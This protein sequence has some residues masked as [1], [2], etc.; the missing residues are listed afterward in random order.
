MKKGIRRI[1]WVG[2]QDQ[3]DINTIKLHMLPIGLKVAI[4]NGE[5]LTVSKLDRRSNNNNNNNKH[6][7]INSSTLFSSNSF[8]Q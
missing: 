2:V 6:S 5:V 8:Q 1:K 7:I 4:L 3:E